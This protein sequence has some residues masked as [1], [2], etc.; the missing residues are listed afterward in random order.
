MLWWRSTLNY[1]NMFQGSIVGTRV[2]MFSSNCNEWSLCWMW[3]WF[4]Q[5]RHCECTGISTNGAQCTGSQSQWRGMWFVLFI[6]YT[7]INSFY[8]KYRF[9]K[10]RNI[11]SFN[12]KICNYNILTV[13]EMKGHPFYSHNQGTGD[14][15]VTWQWLGSTLTSLLLD[16][17]C[18]QLP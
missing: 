14:D 13:K 12:Y 15:T 3:C 16:F 18:D 2:R 17:Y 7:N 1:N 9:N 10:V 11:I 6:Y 4:T 8:N 5:R